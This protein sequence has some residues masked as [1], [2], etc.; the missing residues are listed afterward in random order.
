MKARRAAARAWAIR[1]RAASSCSVRVSSR[2]IGYAVGMRTGY[3]LLGLGLALVGCGGSSPQPNET[4]S[5]SEVAQ[6]GSAASAGECR[7][8][9]VF[10]DAGAG[11][12]TAYRAFQYC[13]GP[14]AYCECASDDPTTCPSSA[15]KPVGIGDCGD[16]PVTCVNRCDANE[17]AV[18]CSGDWV[19]NIQPDLR[20]LPAAHCRIVAS[21]VT[22]DS[23]ACCLC[24]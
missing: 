22:D 24:Q 9:A 21:S 17:Y 12:C 18:S 5:H 16:R 10:D 4:T 14:S 8:A 20:S 1:P 11:A 13:T 15:E 6:A 19:H 3:V 2:A 7:R 23:Y